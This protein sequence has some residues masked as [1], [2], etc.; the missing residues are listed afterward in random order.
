[1]SDHTTVSEL[2]LPLIKSTAT[3]K[4]DTI[5]QENVQSVHR[6]FTML[7][8]YGA[9]G[10][11]PTM[12]GGMG[13]SQEWVDTRVL[14]G[15]K[16]YGVRFVGKVYSNG[17]KTKKEALRISPVKTAAKLA[18]QVAANAQSEPYKRIIGALKANIDGFDKDPLFGVHKYTND[19]GAPTYS[20]DI[21]GTNEPWYLVNA[22]SMVEVPAD[23]ADFQLQ[24][25]AGDN[26]AIDFMEDSMAF[27]WR[28]VC[29]YGAGFWANSIRS[30]AA[31][32][33]E[34][35][36]A[37]LKLG[38][39]FKNDKGERLGQKYTHILVGQNNAAAVEKLFKAQLI[40]GGN[41]N[42]DFGRLQFLVLDELT[43]D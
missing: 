32:T 5:L 33:S 19:V 27:A 4:F 12:L 39:T 25:Y 18:A 10:W 24:I 41:S 37:A 29:I 23:G 13:P 9:E 38:S 3:S 17:T 22:E 8:S 11:V 16:E 14:H 28:R 31:L 34:N 1:M 43:Q 15:T 42:V 20:N 30:G 6:A 35:L 36:R 2:D 40:E 21:A 26:T 7:D